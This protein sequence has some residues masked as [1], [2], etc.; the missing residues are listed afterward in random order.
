MTLFTARLDLGW[1]GGRGGHT[2][3]T[4]NV[5]F[6]AAQLIELSVR[7]VPSAAAAEGMDIFRFS[8]RAFILTLIFLFMFLHA[9]MLIP[10]VLVI[11]EYLIC[12]LAL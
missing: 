9:F 6:I 10:C 5:G 7:Q 8:V 2:E 12:L 3:H 1:A 11:S 4:G